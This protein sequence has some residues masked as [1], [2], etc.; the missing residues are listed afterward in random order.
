METESNPDL[1][2]DRTQRSIQLKPTG[3]LVKFMIYPM[4]AMKWE[5]NE[6]NQWTAVKKDENVIHYIL[7]SLNYE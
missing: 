1:C 5:H 7:T 3:E 6:M 2:D 4:V